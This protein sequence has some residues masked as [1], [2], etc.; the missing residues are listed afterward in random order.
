MRLAAST[1]VSEVVTQRRWRSRHQ[2]L[3]P[4]CDTDSDAEVEKEPT[5][6]I[7]D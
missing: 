1:R 7:A 6:D 2:S 3:A 4:H 5:R